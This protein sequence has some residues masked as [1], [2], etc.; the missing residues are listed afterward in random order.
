[1]FLVPLSHSSN[2]LNCLNINPQLQHETNTALACQNLCDEFV[3]KHTS[4]YPGIKPRSLLPAEK[5]SNHD[6]YFRVRPEI[7]QYSC[8][9]GIER[10][11]N[12]ISTL[13]VKE[14]ANNCINSP[15]SSKINPP[16][17]YELYELIVTQ[18]SHDQTTQLTL[19]CSLFC[20]SDER[21][22]VFEAVD[23]GSCLD[24]CF[25]KR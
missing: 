18:S 7:C 4:V 11:K 25:T 14:C 22:A 8:Q 21:W 20:N 12:I 5:N 10:Y 17:Q 13:D 16:R 1:M 2:Q 19:D 23:F 9:A 6:T 24:S 3:R 15:V